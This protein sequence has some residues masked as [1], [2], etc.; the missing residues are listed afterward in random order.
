MKNRENFGKFDEA[1]DTFTF[2][3][4]VK[5]ITQDIVSTLPIGVKNVIGNGVETIGNKA[6][7]NCRSLLTANFPNAGTIRSYAFRFCRSL[8]AVRFDAVTEIGAYAFE[9]CRSL[10]T[11]RFDAVTEIRTCAF[12]CCESLI[13]LPE[14]A[15]PKVNIIGIGAFAHCTFLTEVNFPNAGTIRSHA[16]F[17]CE[18]LKTVKFK[19][20]VLIANNAFEDCPNIE[21]QESPCGKFDEATDT[22]TFNNDVKE[23]TQDIVSTLPIGVENVI[24][25]GVETIGDQA[26]EDC[27]SL[28]TANFPNARKIGKYAFYGCKKLKKVKF[29]LFASIADYAFEDCPKLVK[30]K[31]KKLKLCDE[32]SEKYDCMTKNNFEVMFENKVLPLFRL[33]DDEALFTS[34]KNMYRDF[35]IVEDDCHQWCDFMKLICSENKIQ[36][37]Y[38]DKQLLIAVLLASCCAADNIGVADAVC[39]GLRKITKDR[40]LQAEDYIKQAESLRAKIKNKINST[41]NVEDLKSIIGIGLNNLSLSQEQKNL[42]KTIFRLANNASTK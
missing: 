24:G 2:N 37:R 30:S 27:R 13:T 3:N 8:K 4:D 19:D 31:Y 18:N 35:K 41:D 7:E 6:F 21:S 34:F 14:D 10:K 40:N 38:L 23:I 16:F 33:N 17:R 25:N 39:R 22:F 36:E 1:T 5:E 15:F 12:R 11:V 28:L 32:R 20:N 42:V 29:R 26:F 9:I